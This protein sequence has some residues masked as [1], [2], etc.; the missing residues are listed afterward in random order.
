MKR[1]KK[2]KKS[3]FVS[4]PNKE[5]ETYRKGAFIGGI[6]GGATGLLLGK[7][8]ILC[9]VIGIIAGGYLA[10]EVNKDDTGIITLKDFK[11]KTE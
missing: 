2:D 6:L 7:R 4:E 3:N 1:K 11:N 8:I 9:T 10:Y 5:F